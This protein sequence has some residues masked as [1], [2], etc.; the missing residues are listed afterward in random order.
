MTI[1]AANPQ[2]ALLVHSS[3]VLDRQRLHFVLWRERG[4]RR[5]I[6]DQWV[7]TLPHS[8]IGA[9]TETHVLAALH[10]RQCLR[11]T[12]QIS[13]WGECDSPIDLVTPERNA[14]HLAPFREHRV[15]ADIPTHGLHAHAQV[16][17]ARYV[18]SSDPT[19]HIMVCDG[20]G[21]LIDLFRAPHH[22]LTVDHDTVVEQLLDRGYAREQFTSITPN[23]SDRV[24]HT[25]MANLRASA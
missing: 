7:Q 21:V 18:G 19:L 3:L 11:S 2:Y 25:A 12:S 4:S 16:S 8:F 15:F 6:A 23:A 22:A 20:E 14:S 5:H 24:F 13:A 1:A 17:M 9:I 10:Q